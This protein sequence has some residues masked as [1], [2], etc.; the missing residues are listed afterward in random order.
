[1]DKHPWRTAGDLHNKTNCHDREGN[2]VFLRSDCALVD[3]ATE[4]A[5]RLF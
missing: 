1:M 4:E 5:T 2:P 3:G